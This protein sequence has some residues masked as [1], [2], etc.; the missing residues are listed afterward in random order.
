VVRYTPI[1][2]ITDKEKNK[3]Y[4]LLDTNPDIK[5]RIKI[6]LLANDGYTVPEIREM[7][8]TY[9]KTL[10]KW[11]HKFNNEGTEGLFTKIDYS[12][13]IKIDNDA[14]KEI[15]KIASTN[16][17]DLGLKFS[18][19]SLRSLAGYLTKEDKKKPTYQEELDWVVTNSTRLKFLSNLAISLKGNTLILVNY[20]DL[21]GKPLYE[22]IKSKAGDR[23]V[24]FI[25]QAVDGVERDAI[26]AIIEQETDA[27]VIAT[28][29]TFS[30]GVSIK[31][32]NNVILGSPSK[33]TIRILQSIGR[34]LRK[35]NG[36][37]H[38]TLYDL[39]DDISHRKSKNYALEH[40]VERIM[41][42]AKQQFDYKLI[43]IDV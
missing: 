24:F 16:P 26:R 28:Y 30:T 5:Y 2:E 12:P 38:C 19:W 4:A 3:L 7:T 10:R 13:M 21:H 39:I 1:R 37:T 6:I 23:K 9:D 36:K 43:K 29:Q 32:L 27:I 11:I 14:R 15:V 22:A 41:L 17:R 31:R 34:G 18:T 33:S 20:V 35:G 25:Y 42:Y 8:N 40:G